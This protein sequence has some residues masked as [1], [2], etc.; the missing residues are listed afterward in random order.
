MTALVQD[1]VDGR[2]DIVREL[3]IR[4]ARRRQRRRRLALMITVAGAVL[5]SYVVTQSGGPA[6]RPDSLLARPLHFPSL[7]A[8]GRCPVSSGRM[9]NNQFFVGPVLGSGPVRVLLGDTGDI[10]HGRVDL[11]ARRVSGWFALQTL[12][13]AMPGYDGPFVVRAARVGAES[14]IE[15]QSGG[16]GQLPGSGPLVVPAGPTINT[17]Y[18]NF[19]AGHRRD[20]VTGRSVSTL[21]GYGYRTVPVGTWV[22][23]AGCYAW[24]VDGRGFSE[25]IV[26]SAR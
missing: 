6:P 18:T 16:N 14:P 3:L 4:E 9:V 15:V 17:F 10:V 26:V 8:G 1:P 21:T 22:R 7:G 19:R 11:A 2:E 12:W 20:T 23:S 5:A 25:T 24:Q 13:F